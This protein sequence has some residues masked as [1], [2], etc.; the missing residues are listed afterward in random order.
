MIG[1]VWWCSCCFRGSFWGVLG[2]F[3][4]IVFCRPQERR[5]P[6]FFPPFRRATDQNKRI[7]RPVKG[8]HEAL[9]S[10]FILNLSTQPAV[11]A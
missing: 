7:Q 2:Q 5:I 10:L 3:F 9:L 11:G 4:G 8:L 1:V 6:P